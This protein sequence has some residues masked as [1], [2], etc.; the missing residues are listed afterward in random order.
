[1]VY[2]CVCVLLRFIINQI[3][4][5]VPEN[6][7]ERHHVSSQWCR[8][9]QNRNETYDDLAGLMGGNVVDICVRVNLMMRQAPSKMIIVEICVMVEILATNCPHPK[10]RTI[11]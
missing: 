8:A 9:G 7:N 6:G 10:I 2:V 4:N 11:Y 5:Q 1:M 3:N